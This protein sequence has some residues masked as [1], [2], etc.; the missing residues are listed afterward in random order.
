M[1][2]RMLQ[3]PAGRNVWWQRRNIKGCWHECYVEV[4][5]KCTFNKKTTLCDAGSSHVAP[6]AL[7]KV[8]AQVP[9]CPGAFEHIHN[10]Q[11]CPAEFF[12]DKKMSVDQNTHTYS[13][14]GL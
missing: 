8:L 6:Q 9:Q 3:R 5:R 2:I 13:Q 12:L 14:G 4:K 1:T 11:V 10:A 7:F